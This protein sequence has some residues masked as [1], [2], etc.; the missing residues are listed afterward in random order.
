M[1]LY[2]FDQFADFVICFI[3]G[4]TQSPTYILGDPLWILMAWK[5]MFAFDFDLRFCSHGNECDEEMCV[6]ERNHD[7][8]FNNSRRRRRSSGVEYLVGF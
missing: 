3:P 5:K 8:R 7:N 4:Y 6:K 2:L 1:K